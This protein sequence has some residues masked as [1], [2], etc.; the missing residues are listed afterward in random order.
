MD[1]ENCSIEKTALGYKL[2]A[3]A[4]IIAYVRFSVGAVGAD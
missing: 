2:L 3:L 1:S 4:P